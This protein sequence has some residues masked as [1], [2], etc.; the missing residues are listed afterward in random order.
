LDAQQAVFANGDNQFVNTTVIV[1]CSR[2]PLDVHPFF[3]R[4]V[5]PIESTL[6][7]Q[8]LRV[9]IPSLQHFEQFAHSIRCPGEWHD[10][11]LFTFSQQNKKPD[12]AETSNAK[13]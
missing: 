12:W 11:R 2:H 10:L 1:R 13:K 4:G 5:P 8:R 6:R 3:G 9:S 7:S